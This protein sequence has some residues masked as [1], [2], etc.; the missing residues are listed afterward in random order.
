[1]LD[2]N[3]FLF[4]EALDSIFDAISTASKNNQTYVS[5]SILFACLNIPHIML[6]M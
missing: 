5:G 6:C 2:G 4:Q 1:M 3:A